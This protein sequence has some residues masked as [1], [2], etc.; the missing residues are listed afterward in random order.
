MRSSRRWRRFLNLDE[1]GEFPGDIPELDTMVT[2]IDAFRFFRERTGMDKDV[3]T[4]MFDAALPIPQE[5][6]SRPVI[7]TR[8]FHDPFSKWG[9]TLKGYSVK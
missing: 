8:G 2:V 4:S 3:Q 1:S 7:W 5:F 6:D 9:I